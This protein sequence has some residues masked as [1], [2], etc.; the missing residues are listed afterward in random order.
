MTL[1]A[2]LVCLRFSIAASRW[3]FKALRDFV[4]ADFFATRFRAVF[5]PATFS[6]LHF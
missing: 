6:V 1:V 3:R 4:F 5:L 2:A